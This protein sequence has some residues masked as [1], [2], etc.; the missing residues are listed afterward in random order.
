MNN[1]VTAGFDRRHSQQI[2][3][4]P[5]AVSS[6][7]QVALKRSYVRRRVLIDLVVQG[8]GYPETIARRQGLNARAVRGALKGEGARYA[9]ELSL[10]TLGLVEKVYERK[11]EV[12]R[13]TGAGRQFYLE[14]PQEE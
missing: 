11:L 1:T 7:R 10:Q 8:E 3:M 5:I 4:I 2:R 12:Y 13:P 14:L 6:L 9:R